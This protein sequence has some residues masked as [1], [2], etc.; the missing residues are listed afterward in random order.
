MEKS[1]RR[2]VILYTIF[3]IFFII[4]LG[5]ASS[6][7]EYFMVTGKVVGMHNY[8]LT[9][10]D[11]K[12]QTMYFSTGRRTV[13]VP[14]REPNVDERVKVTYYVRRGDNVATQVE[15]LSANK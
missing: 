7:E 2:W 13:F 5:I 9:V 14:T 8:Q 12:G 11:D 15:I 10:K 1:V 3:T 4:G 6:A